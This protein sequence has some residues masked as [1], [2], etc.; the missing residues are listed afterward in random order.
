[1]LLTY[2]H[3]VKQII[4]TENTTSFVKQVYMQTW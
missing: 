3:T 2:K 1:M 4:T